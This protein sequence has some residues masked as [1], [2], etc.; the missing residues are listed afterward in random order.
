MDSLAPARSALTGFWLR[1]TPFAVSRTAQVKSISPA[2]APKAFGATL[3]NR[4]H[5]FI[6]LVGRGCCAA[7]VAD[8]QVRPTMLLARGHPRLSH[9]TAN[10]TNYANRR[11]RIRF[12]SCA[13]VAVCSDGAAPSKVI[14]VSNPIKVHCGGRVVLPRAAGQSVQWICRMG[15]RRVAVQRDHHSGL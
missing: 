12:A 14:A 1:Q 9:P 6:K 2:A 5:K 15:Q 3:R 4:P 7:G 13:P 11:N 8:Q 10:H